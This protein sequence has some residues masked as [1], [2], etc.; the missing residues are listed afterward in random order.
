MDGTA[1]RRYGR[2]GACYS[3]F[4][5][6]WRKTAYELASNDNV[7]LVLSKAMGE[8]YRSISLVPPSLASESSSE[9][10]DN[11]DDLGEEDEEGLDRRQLGK[12]TS[13]TLSV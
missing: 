1:C 10:D 9:T 2:Y 3:P 11:D 7:R 13:K 8:A 4:A 5:S 6:E 12:V